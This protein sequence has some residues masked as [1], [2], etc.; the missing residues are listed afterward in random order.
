MGNEAYQELLDVRG[1]L[2]DVACQST[3]WR[4]PAVTKKKFP[5]WFTKVHI[6]ED[7][8]LKALQNTTGIF[9]LKTSAKIITLCLFEKITRVAGD[10]VCKWNVLKG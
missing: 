1:M 2:L 8:P 9:L 3:P 5:E 10:S 4:R 6:N 7:E